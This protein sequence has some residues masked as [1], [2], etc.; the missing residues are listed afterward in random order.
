MK[1]L[2]VISH[3]LPAF[4]FGGPLQ[5]AHGLGRALVA[6][7]H[8]VTVCCT[9]LKDSQQLLDVPLDEPVKVDGITV[10]YE[11]VP[12]AR[13]WGY[14]PGM[15]RRV[16]RECASHDLVLTH[17]HYQY[18][19]YCGGRRARQARRPYVVFSHGTLNRHGVAASSHVVKRLYLALCEA[20]NFRRALFT[21]YHSPDEA[22]NSLHFGASEILPIGVDFQSLQGPG[23]RGDFRRKHSQIG[24]RFL[25]L[26]LGRLSTGKGL[27]FLLPAFQAV[28]RARD[29]HLVLMGGDEFG[30][31]AFLE[32]MT[33]DLGIQDRVTFT[34]LLLGAE[35]LA[36]MR[37]ADAF[38]LPSR[39][40][41]LS[42]ATLEAMAVKLP[43]II[44]NRMGLWPQVKAHDCGLVIDYDTGAVERA[45]HEIAE[46]PDREA[47]GKRGHDYV[48]A[49]YA[50]AG[51]AGDLLQMVA[52]RQRAG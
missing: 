25:Y 52:K 21:V 12:Y 29:A 4:S 44:T 15:D 7:G 22:K 19:S 47:M 30:Y 34:G 51:I 10:Y 31:R 45:L 46:R 27:D 2:Q 5:V 40:E 14:A 48:T 33:R 17:F 16:A 3:Y 37:D 36:V 38:V 41:G 32:G 23:G 50:W 35:K 8:E 24:G 49:N 9:N 28:V 20:R 6:A 13:Y 39:S 26:Y 1:I 11:P 18:A 42:L 43:V